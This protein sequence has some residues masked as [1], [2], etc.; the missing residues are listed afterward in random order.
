MAKGTD[1]EQ[2]MRTRLHGS[3]STIV[4][5]L[6]LVVA[7]T[8]AGAWAISAN[9]VGPKQIK[10][11]AVRAQEIKRDAV[12]PAELAADSVESAEIAEGAVNAANLTLPPPV[13]FTFDQEATLRPG[14][15][16][17]QRL[18]VL[19]TFEK[20]VPESVASVSW[21]G[22]VA[23]DFAPCVFQLRVDGATDDRGS[24]EAFVENSTTTSV[25]VQALFTGLAA[26]PH[27]IEVWARNTS[28]EGTCRVGP[29]Q[30]QV[31][32]TVVVQ[33]VVS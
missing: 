17:A 3:Y 33:E 15:G 4:S 18:V 10:R 1:K 27:Q 7:L 24:A 8:S 19:G 30:A 21:S 11:N 20:S 16:E 28:T 5:T 31:G 14:T 32:Q 12:K 25:S 22:A 9:S 2:V 29:P 26:G 6:A 23:A 13:T